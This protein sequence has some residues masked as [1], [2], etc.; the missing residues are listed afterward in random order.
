[1]VVGFIG[2]SPVIDT[3]EGSWNVHQRI[4]KVEQTLSTRQIRL[5]FLQEG[6][7]HFF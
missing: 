4:C 7:I 6:E 2:H 3:P 1:M 5:L